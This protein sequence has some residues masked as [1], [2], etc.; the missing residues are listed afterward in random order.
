MRNPK[1]SVLVIGIACAGLSL[2]LASTRSAQPPAPGVS[3]EDSLRV[4]ALSVA[5]DVSRE[6]PGAWR[7]HFSDTPAFFMVSNGRLV[8]SDSESATRSIEQLAKTIRHIELRWGEPMRIDPL[9]P[10]VAMLAM[11]YLEVREGSAGRSV[12]ETG[13]FTGLAELRGGRWQFRNAHWSVAVPP[14]AVR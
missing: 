7:R 10:G 14:G 13:Y 11:P 5:R 2:G 8:F 4:F 12:R 9:A 3:T 6:G 1:R